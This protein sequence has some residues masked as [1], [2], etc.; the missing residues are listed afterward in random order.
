MLTTPLIPQGTV[1]ETDNILGVVATAFVPRTSVVRG[2]QVA[3]E[4]DIHVEK[5]IGKERCVFGIN[6][7]YV[8]QR[9][10]LK[11]LDCQKREIPLRPIVSTRSVIIAG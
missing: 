2:A 8:L 5:R 11:C 1:I 6:S 4:V 7:D 3:A 9:L 10:L